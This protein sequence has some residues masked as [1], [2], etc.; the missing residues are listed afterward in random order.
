VIPAFHESER[1]GPFLDDLA[2]ELAGFTA[3][4]VQVVDDGSDPAEGQKLAQLVDGKRSSMPGLNPVHRLPR[5]L[6]KGAAVRAGWDLAAD[7]SWLAFADADG[8]TPARE[9]ARLI[10]IIGNQS[11]TE[12]PTA[13]FASRILMLGRQVDRQVRRHL[14]GR[15]FA[16]LVSNL[17]DIRAYDTQCGCKFVPATA[18]RDVRGGLQCKGF[19]FDVELLVALLDSGWNVREEPV[20]WNEIPGGKVRILR[21]SWRMFRELLDIR[22]RR[23]EA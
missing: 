19:S 18:Y 7:E 15:V 22:A 4:T 10:K 23:G 8:A 21:D 6:G 17:L 13:V 5:N 9:I 1:I 3:V 12:Q 20:D 2:R 14:V 16:T 11:D